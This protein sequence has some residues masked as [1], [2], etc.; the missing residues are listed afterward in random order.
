MT[1]LKYIHQLKDAPY[2]NKELGKF[3]IKYLINEKLPVSCYFLCIFLL[4]FIHISYLPIQKPPVLANI[5]NISAACFKEIEI[6]ML[7]E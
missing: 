7:S 3:S 4:H 5:Y 6:F 1:V 2:G